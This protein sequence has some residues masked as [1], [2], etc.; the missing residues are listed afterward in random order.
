M[1]WHWP[2]E[3]E[4]SNCGSK[5]LASSKHVHVCRGSK[6]TQEVILSANFTSGQDSQISQRISIPT[7]FLVCCSV[8]ETSRSE[9]PESNQGSGSAGRAPAAGSGR[10][11]R[12]QRATC[13]RDA[14][15]A[16]APAA[17]E[18][19]HSASASFSSVYFGFTYIWF[20][21]SLRHTSTD[22]TNF[23]FDFLRI[24]ERASSQYFARIIVLI[25]QADSQ[26]VKAEMATVL[27]LG[28]FFSFFALEESLSYI[29]SPLL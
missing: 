1:F 2:I 18:Q 5:I 3:Q 25:V 15:G 9:A 6:H 19:D 24:H 4:H 29:F 28:D 10:R 13:P 14:A 12:R 17:S 27:F 20:Q 16:R 21:Q 8:G 22:S 26:N 23:V 7:L 11:C